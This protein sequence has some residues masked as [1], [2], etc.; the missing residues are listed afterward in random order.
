MMVRGWMEEEEEEDQ[1]GWREGM[2]TR[3]RKREGIQE[4]E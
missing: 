4:L 2:Q 3:K 1:E